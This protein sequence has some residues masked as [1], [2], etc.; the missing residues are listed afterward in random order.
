MIDIIKDVT[1]KH[2]RVQDQ[3]NETVNVPSRWFE[4]LTAHVS[5]GLKNPI[6]ALLNYQYLNGM[7]EQ[8]N[9]H[10]GNL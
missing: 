8:T 1:L 3:W 4:G 2:E 6:G 10:T 9:H 7:V 5:E